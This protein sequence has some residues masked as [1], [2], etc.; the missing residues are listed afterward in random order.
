MLNR[1]LILSSFLSVCE[2][3]AESNL[4]HRQLELFCICHWHYIWHYTSLS[5]NEVTLKDR[6]LYAALMPWSS[7]R[8]ESARALKLYV[9]RDKKGR[10]AS[11]EFWLGKLNHS[12]SQEWLSCTSPAGSQECVLWETCENFSNKSH[13]SARQ[14]YGKQLLSRGTQ[15]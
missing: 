10:S 3:A 4:Y 1:L 8:F 12:W 11:K 14:A 2:A 6:T 5:R 9:C 13:P 15:V 7:R